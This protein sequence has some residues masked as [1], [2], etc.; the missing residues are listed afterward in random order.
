MKD[1]Q[2]TPLEN[3]PPVVGMEVDLNLARGLVSVTLDYLV[4][5]YSEREIMMMLGT[6]ADDRPALSTDQASACV[7]LA[8]RE[9]RA[10]PFDQKF[11]RAMAESAL[12]MLYKKMLA[13]EDYGGALGAMKEYVR[14]N[15]LSA[16]PPAR[17]PKAVGR[18]SSPANGPD[19]D[20]MFSL[21]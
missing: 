16:A 9:L 19:L 15:N 13:A 17:K 21:Q 7:A 11:K 2:K 1:N 10:D 3:S 14:L 8:I 5:G 20:A 12:L 4:Q 6:G 18:T